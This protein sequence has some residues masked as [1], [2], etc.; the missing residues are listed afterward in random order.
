MCLLQ[1][2]KK[3]KITRHKINIQFIFVR[4]IEDEFLPTTEGWRWRIVALHTCVVFRINRSN[5]IRY[6]A[7]EEKQKYFHEKNS[8]I[9]KRSG[10]RKLFSS[11]VVV[12]VVVTEKFSENVITFFSEIW[13]VSS[14]LYGPCISNVRPYVFYVFI[15]YCLPESIR[16]SSVLSRA[17][18]TF[19][20]E[21]TMSH[22]STRYEYS[23]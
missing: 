22:P 6:E 12:L 20:A 15:Y 10:R 1:S 19:Q 21:Y 14:F 23:K 4:V 5:I 16:I 3:E 11:R 2:K 17:I 8:N 18:W 13:Y 7:G 9:C